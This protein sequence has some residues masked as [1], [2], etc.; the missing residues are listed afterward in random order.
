[1]SRFSVLS[2][3]LPFFEACDIYQQ[4]KRKELICARL[5]SYEHPLFFRNNPYDFVT[6]CEVTL[7][8]TYHCALP[9]ADFIIDGGG[10]IGLT[11]AYFAREYP[12]ALIAT[13]EPE[14]NNFE[15]L[16]KNTASSRMIRP[17]FGGIWNK[18]TNLQIVDN[19]SGNNAFTVTELDAPATDSIKAYTIPEI[20]ALHERSTIDIVKLD[21][22]GAEK[23]VFASGYENWLP[24]TRLLIVELHDRMQLGSSKAVFT[25]VSKYDFSV[26]V[27]G[28]NLMFYNNSML[29]S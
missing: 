8:E 1:M 5:R 24:R 6:F 3:H 12:D 14:G 13:V 19:G 10:N 28:E 9:T 21:I 25:A 23:V 4:L 15:L 27:H 22:E 20:M 18:E 2:K 17:L 7:S 26:E 29:A 11:A 16:K